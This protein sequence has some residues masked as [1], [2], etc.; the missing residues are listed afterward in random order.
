M[1]RTHD[2]T[3]LHTYLIPFDAEYYS[4]QSVRK[5]SPSVPS[6]VSLLLPTCLTIVHFAVISILMY[7]H[8]LGVTAR[9]NV[10]IKQQQESWNGTTSVHLKE[11]WISR[12]RNRISDAGR[13][14]SF[15]TQHVLANIFLCMPGV[16]CTCDACVGY[17]ANCVGKLYSGPFFR[18]TACS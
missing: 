3:N 6:P 12:R 15:V 5:T 1:Q 7:Q 16:P 11:L 10:S 14:T 13:S 2:Q 9:V 17:T 8:S 18:V 4:E